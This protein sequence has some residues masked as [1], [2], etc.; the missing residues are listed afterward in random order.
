MNEFSEQ[1]PK[2]SD[3]ELLW[4]VRHKVRRAILL[5]VGEEGRI[6]ATALKQKL[7][8]STGSLYYNLRQMSQLITQDERKSYRLTEDGMRIFKALTAQSGSG[9]N[10]VT[11]SS[12]AAELFSALFFPLW[13]FSPIYESRVV[14]SVLGP[15][16]VFVL[17]FVLLAGRYEL[18]LLNAS[19]MTPVNHP[20]FAV[21]L[22]TTYVAGLAV[23]NVFSF[24]F[25]GRFR[26]FGAVVKE[27]RGSGGVKG[28]LAETGKLTSA[29]AVAFLPLGLVPGIAVIDRVNQSSFLSNL[30]VR[31]TLLI[32][33]QTITIFLISAVVAYV[34]KMKWQNSMGV[35]LTFFY[36]SHLVNYFKPLPG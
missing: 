11:P 15:L 22:V 20:L 29:M 2:M 33:S 26:T 5:A 28:L 8:I 19:P 25:S 12:K 9:Q 16:A 7:G 6:G 13:L 27:F 36:L 10:V 32:L 30:F 24:L 35:A 34:K 1:P 3:E 23:I 21:K 4:L 18:F 14:A 17:V 31:D